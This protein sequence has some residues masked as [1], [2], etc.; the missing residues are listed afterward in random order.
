MWEQETG[1]WE[2]LRSYMHVNVP[3]LAKHWN[4]LRTTYPS[5]LTED[6]RNIL[7]EGRIFMNSSSKKHTNEPPIHSST[8]P[9][10]YPFV[11]STNVC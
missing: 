10:I 3:S 11:H 5:P 4:L 7:T 1:K 2:K 9:S 8:H 6:T